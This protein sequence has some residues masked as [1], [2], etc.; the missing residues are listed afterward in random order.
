MVDMKKWDLILFFPQNKKYRIRKIDNF[1]DKVQP[2][3][4]RDLRNEF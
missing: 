2:H 3:S 1:D 4:R